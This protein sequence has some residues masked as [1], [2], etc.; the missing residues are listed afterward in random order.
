MISFKKYHLD[1][2]YTYMYNPDSIDAP[3]TFKQTFGKNIQSRIIVPKEITEKT[4]EYVIL[5]HEIEYKWHKIKD[6]L[7]YLNIPL[8]SLQKKGIENKMLFMCQK[9]FKYLSAYFN[10]VFE[11]YIL[12]HLGEKMYEIFNSED[13]DDDKWIIITT[14]LEREF[15]I[16]ANAIIDMLIN[17]EQEQLRIRETDI[18]KI[19]SI[20]SSVSLTLN[21]MHH[22]GNMFEDYGGLI[23]P[24]EFEHISNL[25]TKKW[26]NELEQEFQELKLQ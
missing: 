5:L 25:S 13:F 6:S 11:E 23:E 10:N 12:E 8:S 1:E 26:D 18:S 4:I 20:V 16:T 17:I 15:R 2:D 7:T 24:S 22:S 9:I 19:E 21:F 3:P 14:Y